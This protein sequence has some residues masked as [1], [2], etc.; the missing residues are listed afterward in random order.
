MLKQSVILIFGKIFGAILGLI[1]GIF[2]A[3]ILGPEKLGQYQIFL[4]TQTIL[5]TAVTLGIGNASI[6]F[7]NK[8]II[9]EKTIV[10]SFLKIFIVIAFVSCIGF[11]MVVNNEISYF[12]KLNNSAFILFLIGTASLIITSILRPILYARQKVLQVTWV[13]LLPSIILIVGIICLVVIEK[14]NV[15]S[16]LAIWGIGNFIALVFSLFFH[17][18]N[19][20]ISEKI[21]SRVILDV[22]S[23]GIKLSASNLLFILISHTSVFFI[24]KIS[25]NGFADVGL[26]SRAIAISSIVYMIPTAVGPL[27]FSRW[28][29]NMKKEEYEYE[30]Q[31]SLRVFNTL[32]FIVV[33]L[34]SIFSNLIIYVLY[35][36]EFLSVQKTLIVLLISLI[37]Q[38]VSEI[39]NN[40]L[41]S[42]GKAILT[43]YSL[44]ISFII[45]I[46]GNVL[47]VPIYGIN[48]AAMA[49]LASSCLN[50]FVLYYFVAKDIKI[51]IFSNLIIRKEDFEFLIKS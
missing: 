23:Y 29:S 32:S 40:Y 2:L 27:L 34:G 8:N 24:N 13:N 6:Y 18:H 28:S 14:F 33:L 48:G 35:G 50:S 19:I 5:I 36:V 9:S 30:I 15:S 11:Y 45:I 44:L 1:S 10:S 39:L 51:N 49:V 47:L 7:I 42:Q 21:K 31:K 43:M 37:F 3:R 20:S 46:G 25:N 41:A 38:V 16:V 22:G 12:G 4:S 17:R 26:Y